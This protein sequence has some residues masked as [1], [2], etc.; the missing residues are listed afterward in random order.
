MELT[1]SGDT[2][3]RWQYDRRVH[4]C[5]NGIWLGQLLVKYRLCRGRHLLFH[6]EVLKAG[7]A[8]IIDAY[9]AEN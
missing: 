2:Q 6:W 1:W 7:E 4:T 5:N 9:I 8:P 3:W